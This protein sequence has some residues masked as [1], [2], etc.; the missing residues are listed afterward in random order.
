MKKYWLALIGIFALPAL[1]GYAVP[2][3]VDI[4]PV[5]VNEVP[6]CGLGISQ[7]RYNQITDAVSKAKSADERATA[8]RTLNV[9]QTEAREVVTIQDLAL[10]QERALTKAQQPGGELYGADSYSKASLYFQ[11][12]KCTSDA[13]TKERNLF[14]NAAMEKSNADGVN[15][16]LLKRVLESTYNLSEEEGIADAAETVDAVAT[17]K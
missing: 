7:S 3:K 4:G 10:R 14:V 11:S 13:K 16:T 1:N 5:T 15:L 6:G 8:L 17:V 2:A 12:D 9:T